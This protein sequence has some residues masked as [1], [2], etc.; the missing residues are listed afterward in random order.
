MLQLTPVSPTKLNWKFFVLKILK[1]LL[2][3]VVRNQ[4]LYRVSIENLHFD[5][6]NSPTKIMLHLFLPRSLS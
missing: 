1:K 2:E 5:I 4:I 6:L 3:K